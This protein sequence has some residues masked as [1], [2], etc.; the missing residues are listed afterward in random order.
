VA[1][2][3]GPGK[4]VGTLE[5]EG[6][7]RAPL[8]T[9]LSH[10]DRDRLAM[11][12]DL[13]YVRTRFPPCW[14]PAGRGLSGWKG[15]PAP[16]DFT[17][18]ELKAQAELQGLHLMECAGNTRAAHFGMISVASWDGVPLSRLLD[19]M[20][21]DKGGGILVSGFDEY[22]AQPVTPSV[23]GASW[24]F[25]RQDIEDSRAFLA[26]RIVERLQQTFEF[27]RPFQDFKPSHYG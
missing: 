12:T 1:V 2:G 16:R 4:L 21:F 23:P 25:S 8:F 11:P 3:H 18:A 20:R 19:R 14:T 10:L 22:A 26:T 24:I 6:E 9:D 7:G 17:M 5:F 27:E 13:F 15:P